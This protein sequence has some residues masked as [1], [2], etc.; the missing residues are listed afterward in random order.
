[1]SQREDLKLQGS[2]IAEDARRVKSNETMTDRID[3]DPIRRSR[4]GQWLQEEP[5]YWQ[6]QET[7]DTAKELPT[8]NRASS[9]PYHPQL[10]HLG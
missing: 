1:M 5:N 8:D 3:G 10:G 6:E 7:L 9:R 4:Q 2:S